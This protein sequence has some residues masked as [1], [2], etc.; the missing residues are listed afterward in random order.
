MVPKEFKRYLYDV[1]FDELDIHKDKRYI[2]AR[3]LDHGTLLD[4]KKIK[5]LF[6][7]KEIIDAIVHSGEINRRTAYFF[8][9]YFNIREPI[10]CLKT[11]STLGQKIL[12][13]Y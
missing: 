9:N 4:F 6:S 8:K 13:P 11:Q 12:W 7:D 1:K 3:V 2:I 5:D 10:V